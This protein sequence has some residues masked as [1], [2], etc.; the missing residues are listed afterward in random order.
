M[1]LVTTR[2][3][4]SITSGATLVQVGGGLS[5]WGRGAGSRVPKVPGYLGF[6]GTW[7]ELSLE[8][9]VGLTLHVPAGFPTPR[10]APGW[11]GW[12]PLSEEPEPGPH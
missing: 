9:C 12:L 4:H 3:Q 2:W 8:A 6:R 10:D 5:Q 11:K 1:L 7:L